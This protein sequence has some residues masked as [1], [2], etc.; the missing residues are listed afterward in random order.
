MK[1]EYIKPTSIYRDVCIQPILH[2]VS[3]A[4]ILTGANNAATEGWDGG[5][6]IGV[7]NDNMYDNDQYWDTNKDLWMD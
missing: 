3:K 2:V 4:K 6:D 7:N 5:K 1:K